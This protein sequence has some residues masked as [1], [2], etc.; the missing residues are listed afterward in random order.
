[1][2]L[3]DF[4]T[5]VATGDPVCI[6]YARSTEIGAPVDIAIGEESIK[7][8]VIE[9][10]ANGCIAH[11]A[12]FE[13]QCIAR[14][15]GLSH[16]DVLALYA[17]GRIVCSMIAAILSDIR[18]RGEISKPGYAL[19]T[20]TGKDGSDPWRMRYGELRG[21]PLELWPRE[22][23]AY[24]LGDITNL[25][26][27]WQRVGPASH[28]ELLVSESGH[29]YWLDVIGAKGPAVDGP[30]V[31]RLSNE[32]VTQC[33]TL[34]LAM[35]DFFHAPSAVDR[36]TGKRRRNMQSIE[37]YAESKGIVERTP[38]G[39]I[40]V[41]EDAIRESEDFKLQCYAHWLG[42]RALR[43]RLARY[44]G[45]HIACRYKMAASGRAIS[46]G[47]DSIE[48]SD[49]VTNMPRK[50]GLRECV[51][52]EPGH[53]FIIADFAQLE[54]A[55]FADIL[56]RRY[57]PSAL[58]ELL[59]RGVDIHSNTAAEL[60]GLT[61]DV[62]KGRV[63]AADEKR[64]NKIEPSPEEIEAEEWRQLSKVPNFAKPAFQGIP[65][66]VRVAWSGYEKRISL[67]VAARLDR[68]WR[69]AVPESVYFFGEAKTAMH[70]GGMVELPNGFAR[71]CD[72]VNNWCNTWFQGWGAVI[73]KD[74]G[75]RAITAGY[76]VRIFAHD[77]LVVQVPDDSHATEKAHHV[78]ELM[79]AAGKAH[80]AEDGPPLR[81]EPV[82]ARRWSKKAKSKLVD[83]RLT[84]WD[85]SQ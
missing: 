31:S 62:V 13:A 33:D 4:E 9:A 26:E 29:Q 5:D 58:C 3:I 42:L 49:N 39:K 22:A 56:Q 30:R 55:T 71:R 1:M 75:R 64:S 12:S 14:L 53:I 61:Y 18:H 70:S 51:V 20:L 44:R 8:V 45:S 85:D 25:A 67:D 48:F 72:R 7:R 73:A 2:W 43:D 17:Q 69:Q 65:G 63:K 59:K 11:G 78:A 38:T 28:P 46:S 57:P 27:L 40:R 52:P 60:L 84:V 6:Q 82:L 79:E 54:I 35:P 77:E 66:L 10:L 74:G 19:A 47:S 23:L 32:L 80:L 50:G 76:D 81:V 34:A 21:V 15:F 16:A 36:R 83:G 41:A 37:A 24:C 68:A